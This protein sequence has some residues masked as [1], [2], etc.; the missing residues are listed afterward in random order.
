MHTNPPNATPL[1]F[2]SC[3][4]TE[5]SD[6]PHPMGEPTGEGAWGALAAHW[7]RRAGFV[8]EDPPGA[9]AL[10]RAWLGPSAV[11]YVVPLALERDAEFRQKAWGPCVEVRANLP[12]PTENYAIARVLAGWMLGQGS[13]P[14]SSTDAFRRRLA[15]VLIVPKAALIKRCLSYGEPLETLADAFVVS[16]TL[17]ALR[18][19]ECFHVP[20][21]L[22]WPTGRIERR[23]LPGILPPDALLKRIA[24][25]ADVP[26]PFR[27]LVLSDP[28]GLVVV[29]AVD[30]PLRACEVP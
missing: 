18:L 27:R 10:A 24:R 29:Q 11:R 14:S 15:A 20:T 23:G 6:N 17:M 4:L 30:G 21:A 3:P 22:I 2:S 1:A 9:G 28:P 12:A 19:G 8:L 16:P 5:N 25:A 26:P 7:Y 13:P